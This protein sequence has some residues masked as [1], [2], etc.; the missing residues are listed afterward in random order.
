MEALW[1]ISGFFPA[2]PLAQLLDCI[3]SARE[4]LAGP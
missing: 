1:N 2:L 4:A 3:L